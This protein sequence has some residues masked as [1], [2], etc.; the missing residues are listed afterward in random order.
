MPVS[1]LPL[2]ESFDPVVEMRFLFGNF[3][4]MTADRIFL[5]YS[6]MQLGGPREREVGGGHAQAAFGNREGRR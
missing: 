4:R 3:K 2:F 5:K 1:P 6:A